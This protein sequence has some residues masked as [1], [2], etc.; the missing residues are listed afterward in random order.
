MNDLPPVLAVDPGRHKR[1]LAVVQS[2]G[3]V[4]HREIVDLDRVAAACAR[5]RST[6]EIDVLVLG[7]RTAAD[8]VLTAVTAACPGL[9]VAFVDEHLSSQTARRRFLDDHPPRGLRRLVPAGLRSPQ[10]PYDDYAAVI[11]AERYWEQ[12]APTEEGTAAP[13]RG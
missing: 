2:T 1:G 7:D 6:H 9:R 4:C 12:A 3:E 10:E 13:H 5:L 11:L 8:S